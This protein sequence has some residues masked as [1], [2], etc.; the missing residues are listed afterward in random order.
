M[1]RARALFALAV[2]V[3]C[4][5]KPAPSGP[6]G[7]LQNEL[8]AGPPLATPGERMSYQLS[9]RGIALADFDL[10][11]GEVTE[12]DGAKVI[13]VTMHAQSTGIARLVA[14]VDDKFT[15][16]LDVA[17][18][19]P[20][21]FECEEFAVHGKSDI[22][23]VLVDYPRR[24]GETMP[25]TVWVNAGAPRPETQ[26]VTARELWD[27]ASFLI[28][29][30]SWEGA[31]GSRTTTEVFRSRYLWKLDIRI[32]NRSSLVT[33]LGELP[34]LRFDAHATKVDRHGRPTAAAQRDFA[35]C[36][37][38]DNDRVPLAI[39]SDTDFGKLALQIMEYVP[40]THR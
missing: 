13:P 40:G 28:A 3:A 18:G 31:I 36:V 38:D 23:H 15:A 22:E 26:A 20:R 16:W 6:T 30:R 5:S 32:A 2:L 17:T 27:L 1:P 9:L 14:K 7:A 21:R 19:R 10:A 4:G 35:L 29:L 39:V 11:I 24:S 25:L 8:P 37:S 34:A 33:Y 12:L